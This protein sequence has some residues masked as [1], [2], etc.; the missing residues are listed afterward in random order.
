MAEVI[1]WPPFDLLPVRRHWVY[2]AASWFADW[3]LVEDLHCARVTW[4][5]APGVGTAELLWRYGRGM[6]LGETSFATIA[7]MTPR[8]RYYVL[9]I[10]EHDVVEGHP[11]ANLE[12]HGTIEVTADRLDGLWL[13]SGAGGL[14]A[15]P[16]GVQSMQCYGLENLLSTH[17]VTTSR[18]WKSSGG[19]DQLIDEGLAFNADG[20]PNRSTVKSVRGSYL[21]SDDPDTAQYWNTRDAVQYLLT[22]DSPRDGQ[23]DQRLPLRLDA[24]TASALP[25]WD[26]PVLERH[27]R[28]TRELLN[29][30]MPRQRL[31]SYHVSL[32]TD[33]Q[34]LISPFTFN[35]QDLDVSA[36][37]M[38]PANPRQRTLAF[39]RAH[40][41][42]ASVKYSTLDGVDQV[43][44]AGA[45][46]RNCCTVSFADSSWAI[47]WTSGL[48]TEYEQGA[49]T[50]GDYPASAEIE[51]RQRRN[52]D[53]R[54]AD[55]LGTVFARYQ[56]PNTWNGMVKDGLG[57]GTAK[58]AAP[59]DSDASKSYPLYRPRLRLCETIPLLE[60]H[61]YSG[62]KIAQKAAV[63]TGSKP[64]RELRP[65]VLI[66]LP[67]ASGKYTPI[68]KIGA[69]ADLEDTADEGSNRRWHGSVHVVPD[70]RALE[71]HVAGQ[72]QHVVAH[73]HFTPLSGVDDELGEY[74][75]EAFLWTIAFEDGRPC[76]ASYPTAVPTSLEVVRKIRIE[77]GDG[78]R[79]DYV[80][81]NTVV[82][83]DVAAQTLVRS[84]NGG[85]VR[86]D[87]QSLNVAARVAYEWYS[88]PRRALTMRASRVTAAL[89][90][91]DLVMDVGDPELTEIG[92]V[93]LGNVRSCVTEI[94]VEIPIVAGPGPAPPRSITWNTAFGELDPLHYLP[95]STT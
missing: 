49:S 58:P 56:I 36:G 8:N 33:D 5:A 88:Q 7:R 61:D 59:D 43:E 89:R 20:L 22:E 87:R 64:F 52:A 24:A 35:D 75:Y 73:G 13:S 60:R 92:A 28:T 77:A 18:W 93:Q 44:V 91:G 94:S 70:S 67:E 85:F 65:L 48:E 57:S 69:A 39:E 84:T 40:D 63:A 47:G 25:D 3:V 86:D 78:Y 10:V 15:I 6:Q 38:L 74:D 62:D 79:L 95:R 66:P 76:I 12:W 9:V 2:L 71:I 42:A 19:G 4:S 83:L 80:A 27:G 46:R 30:L 16:S 41:L 26:R 72:P 37:H 29:Q 81:P 55:R 82:A 31:L 68:E 14:E 90:I 53:A 21:F 54:K 1:R 34:I 32:A 11:T 45:P 50:A 51:D 23:G 17:T